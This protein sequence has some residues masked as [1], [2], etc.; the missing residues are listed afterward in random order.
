MLAQ[1]GRLYPWELV[2]FAGELQQDLLWDY[3]KPNIERQAALP[4]RNQSLWNTRAKEDS[5]YWYLS[6]QCVKYLFSF[7]SKGA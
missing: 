7:H 6:N 1:Q 5:V 2:A 3:Q 4:G